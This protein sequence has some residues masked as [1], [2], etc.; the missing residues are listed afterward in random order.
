MA[1]AKVEGEE[2]GSSSSEDEESGSE[3]S[4][5]DDDGEGKASEDKGSDVEVRGTQQI[6]R[7]AHVGNARV[8]LKASRYAQCF[9][10]SDVPIYFGRGRK[11]S[12]DL[13]SQRSLKLRV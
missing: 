5:P 10:E 12:M 8:A 11:T 2:K 9:N 3:Q 13:S 6:L 1:E 7:W 4:E